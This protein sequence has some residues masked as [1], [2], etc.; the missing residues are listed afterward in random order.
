MTTEAT[1]DRIKMPFVKSYDRVCVA[2]DRSLEDHIVIWVRQSRS[3]AKREGHTL[4]YK[5]Q[6]IK[7]VPNIFC[8]RP[9]NS[10]MLGSLQNGLI[11]QHQWH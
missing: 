9:R 10:Q 3:P 5:R 2:V 1:C 6:N 11:L 4:P 7:N 8:G